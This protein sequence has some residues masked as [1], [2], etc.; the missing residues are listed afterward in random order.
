MQFWFFYIFF[1]GGGDASNSEHL[2]VFRAPS[3][4]EGRS[5]PVH[6]RIGRGQTDGQT[7]RQTDIATTRPNRPSVPSGGPIRWKYISWWLL[8]IRSYLT[9]WISDDLMG[10]F[11]HLRGPRKSS[12]V[13]G[14]FYRSHCLP[15]SFKTALDGLFYKKS[16]FPRQQYREKLDSNKHPTKLVL[17]PPLSKIH[18]RARLLLYFAIPSESIMHFQNSFAFWLFQCDLGQTLS[19]FQL[20]RSNCQRYLRKRIN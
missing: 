3:K 11:K 9:Y 16:Y 4:G 2:P 20:C 13:Q 10:H 12:G 5:T 15:L 1:W 17:S 6:R 14:D 7:D 19:I 18:S 8:V